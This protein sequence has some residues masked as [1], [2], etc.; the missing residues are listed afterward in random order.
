MRGGAS[1]GGRF[2]SEDNAITETRPDG[3]EIVR[4]RPVPAWETREAMDA[5]CG[6]IND[7]LGNPELDPLLL[8][9]LFVLDFLCIHPFSD[10]NGRMSRLLTLL[11]LYRSGHVVGKYVSVEKLIADSKESYY[12]AL[13]ASSAGWHK[14]K[15]DDLP[16]VRYML[17]VVAAAYREFSSRV[18]ILLAEKM[19]KPDRVR[20]IVRNASGRLTKAEIMDLCPNISQKTVERALHELLANGDVVKIGGR[21]Y[22]SYIWNREKDA[23][24]GAAPRAR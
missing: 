3:T 10:G 24:G 8:M 5:V 1:V 7:A 20:E 13:K 21:R 15:N 23:A 22:A 12:D 14:G 9:P 16:F 11:L 17:G 6:G 18:E 4:F 2:K 19:A